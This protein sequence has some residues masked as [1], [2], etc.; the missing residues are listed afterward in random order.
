MSSISRINEINRLRREKRERERG[1]PWIPDNDCV[2]ERKIKK[3][4]GKTVDVTHKK[5][6]KNKKSKNKHNKSKNH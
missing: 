2:G 1:I 4:K 5:S 3:I 6:S